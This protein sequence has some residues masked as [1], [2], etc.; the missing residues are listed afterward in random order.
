MNTMKNVTIIIGLALLMSFSS[1]ETNT[2]DGDWD[3]NIKLSD[4]AV[5]FSVGAD[6]VTVT[7][8]GTWWWINDVKVNDI[9]FYPSE[10]I[11]TESTNY[12]ITEDCFV[13]ERRNSTTLFIKANANKTGIVRT[14]RVSLEA[15][16]YFDSVTV[17]QDAG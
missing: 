8:E 13:V 10:D 9:Y 5:N 2:K 7:T 16:D 6:S 12:T 11:D 3:D 14:I 4:K 15:G 17:T 1:C